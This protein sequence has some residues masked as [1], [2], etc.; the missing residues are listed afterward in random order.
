MVHNALVGEEG[1]QRDV[2]LDPVAVGVAHKSLRSD[3]RQMDGLPGLADSPEGFGLDGEFPSRCFVYDKR[4][5]REFHFTDVDD[6]IR[7]VEEKIDLDALRMDLIPDMP[8]RIRFGVDTRDA[9]RLADLFEV[10]KAE[11]LE[12]ESA[13]R[14]LPGG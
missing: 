8:P 4:P 12:R 10:L 6:I 7:P 3:H 11:S 9:E 14:G 5:L 2:G 1:V 13:P